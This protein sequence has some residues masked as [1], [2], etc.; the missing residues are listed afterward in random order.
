MPRG[1]RSTWKTTKLKP[2][3]APLVVSEYATSNVSRKALADKFGTYPQEIDKALTEAGVAIRDG[4]TRR[5][6][7]CPV[8]K[9]GRYVGQD[10]YVRIWTP[11]GSLGATMRNS[12]N[13]ALEHRVVM[14]ETIGRPLRRSERVH[15]RNGDK[16][17]NRLKNLELWE[18]SHP[19]GQRSGEKPHCP[20][21]T[22]RGA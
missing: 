1:P 13:Y 12:R 4:R 9:T 8:Y 5:G 3:D 18:E 2:E 10:G 22:C 16:A 19:P 17:D 6:P 21:C 7:E 20:T 14:A 15:H 11:D